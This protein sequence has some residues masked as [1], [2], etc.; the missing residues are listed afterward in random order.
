MINESERVLI[1]APAVRDGEIAQAALRAVD[2]DA[3]VYPT[4]MEVCA[5]MGAG[6]GAVLVTEDRLDSCSMALLR[7]TLAQQPPWSDFP[8]LVLASRARTRERSSRAL[9][10]LGNVTLLDAPLRV[11]TLRRAVEA[12]LRARRRQYAAAKEI[13][14]RDHFLALLGHELRNPLSAI[15]LAAEAASGRS[16]GAARELGIIERQADILRR[17][18]DDLLDVA[19]VTAGKLVLRPTGLDLAA[20]VARVARLMAARFERAGVGFSFDAIGAESP[21][22]VHGDALRLEQVFGNLLTNAVKYTPTGGHVMVSTQVTDTSVVVQI[23]DTGAGIDPG[24]LPRIFEPF[25]QATSTLPRA[26]GGLGVGLT[27]VN[28]IVRLHGGTVTAV[29]DGPGRGSCFEVK[30][31]RALEVSRVEIQ[32]RRGAPRDERPMSIVLVDDHEDS[33]EM[34]AESLLRLGHTVATASTG[35]R[36]ISLILETQPHAAIVDIGLPDVTG[37]EVAARVRQALG[38]G[39]RLIALSGYGQASDRDNAIGAGFDRHLTKPATT[40][41]VTGALLSGWGSKGSR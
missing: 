2:V 22:L 8:L 5:G 10:L 29:S 35:E 4:I 7:D 24:F 18:V 11:R 20:L 17:L 37:L 41:E 3:D 32:E 23:E 26:D 36:G 30:L 34:L 40:A 27:L 6:A 16:T 14:Q 12:S 25:E 1:L 38:A 19:R 9:R 31:P 13:D 39:V 33:L 28:Q 21:A 15:S